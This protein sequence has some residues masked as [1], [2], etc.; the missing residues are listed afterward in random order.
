MAN[1]RGR[2]GGKVCRCCRSRHELS[3]ES[4]V[5]TRTSCF[6]FAKI[7]SDTAKNEPFEIW[8]SRHRIDS[9]APE[10]ETL[11]TKITETKSSREALNAATLATGLAMSEKEAT[12]DAIQAS[13][14]ASAKEFAT[15][16]AVA[17]PRLTSEPDDIDQSQEIDALL[18][19][20]DDGL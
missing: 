4:F 17:R 5:F 19:S 9:V 8:G 3:H 1:M 20:Q 7:G 16:S 10:V 13:I 2:S 18:E 14:Q 11:K 15:A 6:S 12:A